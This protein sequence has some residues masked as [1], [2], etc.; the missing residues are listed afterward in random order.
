MEQAPWRAREA[1]FIVF[2]AFVTTLFFSLVL[3]AAMNAE[4]GGASETNFTLVTGILAE[5]LFGVWV[6]IWIKIRYQRGPAALGL[7]KRP[8]DLSSGV[9]TGLLGLGASLIVTQFVFT[10]ARQ[11]TRGP[12]KTP[13]QI[14]TEVGG[15][16]QIFLAV[17][18]AVVAAPI[19]EEILFRGFLY[20]ALRRWKGVNVGTAISAIIF[21]LSHTD[22]KGLAD[23]LRDSDTA[24][25]I[26][27]LLI[28]LPTL[29]LGVILARVFERRRSLA[30]AIIAHGF[31]N[32]VGVILILTS[33]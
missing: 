9:L 12:V 29:A 30:P 8:G 19:G 14:P 2:F 31:Y 27:S 28:V 25:I 16:F 13:E 1:I 17:V 10:I 7:R 5:A 20:Q 26:S 21:G 3:Y 23:G 15:A 18:L 33:N 4:R 11:L 6:L 22:F 24:L 32:V